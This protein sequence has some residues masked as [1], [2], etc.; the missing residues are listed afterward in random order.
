MTPGGTLET[1]AP[2][3]IAVVDETRWPLVVVTWPAGLRTDREFAATLASLARIAERPE[4]HVLLLD[5]RSARPPT[6]AQLGGASERARASRARACCR[7]IA[8]VARAAVARATIDATR[9]S[10]RGAAR[11][12]HFDEPFGARVAR[13]DARAL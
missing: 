13:V 9:V 1:V 6:P 8:V 10:H 4:P 11:W 2:R 3:G 12:A 5:V 7:A